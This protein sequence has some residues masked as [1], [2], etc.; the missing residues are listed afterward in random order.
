[1]NNNYEK[2]FVYHHISYPRNGT[3]FQ[4]YLRPSHKLAFEK[5]YIEKKCDHYFKPLR[6]KMKKPYKYNRRSVR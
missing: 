5:T 3:G 2:S 6:V 1:M 4:F